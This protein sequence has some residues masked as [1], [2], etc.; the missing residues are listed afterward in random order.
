MAS[1]AIVNLNAPSSGQFAGLLLIQDSNGLPPGTS[2]TSTY[3]SIGGVSSATL[4]GLIYFPK[5]SMTFHG[6]PSTTD[7]KCLLLV[8]GRLNVDATSSLD[9]G[10]CA[11]AGL[12][13]LPMIHKIALA[14]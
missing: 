10:G 4:D 3:S 11:K 8:V 9:A 1:G 13:I 14:E 7:P 12:T 5:S 6:H 2:Y